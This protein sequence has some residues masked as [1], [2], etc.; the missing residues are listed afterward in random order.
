MSP[1]DVGIIGIIA[2]VALLMSSMPVGIAMAVIGVAGFGYL[3]TPDAALSMISACATVSVG[4][5]WGLIQYA[6]MAGERAASVTAIAM[7]ISQ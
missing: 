6:A 5:C 7:P 1:I 2:L 4:S 3:R